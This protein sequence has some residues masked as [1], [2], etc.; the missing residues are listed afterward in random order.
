MLTPRPRVNLLL[1]Y[2]LASRAAWRS[3]LVPATAAG[4][5]AS[6]AASSADPDGDASRASRGGAYRWAEL[7]RRT[8]GV[9]VL[10][11]SSMRRTAASGG[12]D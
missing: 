12:A 10:A 6:D 8:F 3:A 9:D 11:S 4:I 2:R 1:Y 7:M 5:D